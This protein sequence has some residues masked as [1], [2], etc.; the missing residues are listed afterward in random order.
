MS[1]KTKMKIGDL[2]ARKDLLHI[3]YR[4]VSENEKWNAW[5]VKIVSDPK[6]L[7]K[8]GMVFKD[9]DRWTVVK[10]IVERKGC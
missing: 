6:G 3:I 5:N 4:I 2:I 9:D 8:E 10:N 1:E 7:H